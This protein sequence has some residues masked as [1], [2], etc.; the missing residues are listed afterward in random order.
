MSGS[1][2]VSDS[3]EPTDTDSDGL[4]D[5][6]N[7]DDDNDG[8]SDG[9]EELAGTEPLDAT[10]EPADS[11]SNGIPDSFEKGGET[12]AETPI[13][14][15]LMIVV[16]IIGWLL[17]VLMLMRKRK[18]PPLPDEAVVAMEGEAVPEISGEEAGV[19]VAG[20]GEGISFLS[21]TEGEGVFECPDCGAPL[22]E[23]ATVCPNCGAEF[24]DEEEEEIGDEGEEGFECPDCG[25]LLGADASKPVSASLNDYR[26]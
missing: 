20:E 1:N 22:A 23:T 24:E 9:L 5:E 4:P 26:D 12:E 19:M 2:P 15:Y 14:A 10:S 16:A 18:E 6:L 11:N 21:E 3:S 25:A 13:W 17:A 8:W 7:D